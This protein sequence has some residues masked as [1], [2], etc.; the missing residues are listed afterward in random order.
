MPKKCET[1]VRTQRGDTFSHPLATGASTY[2]STLSLNQN[3]VR[4]KPSRGSHSLPAPSSAR[5]HGPR[6]REHDGEQRD[7]PRRPYCFFSRSE[8]L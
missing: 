2:T 4:L 5:D 1:E 3:I 7:E 6:E 8:P